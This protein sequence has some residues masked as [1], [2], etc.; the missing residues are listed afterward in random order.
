M[1]PIER[2]ASQIYLV[3]EQNV[4]LDADLA[5]LYGVETRALVQAVKRNA[6]RFP[7]DFMFQLSKDELESWRSQIVMSNP[8]AKMGLRRQPYAFTEHGVA[9]LSSVLR[10][11][12]AVEIN[13][14]IVRTFVKLRRLLA[15]NAELAL[16]VAQHDQEIGI[17]F[18]H[19]QALLEPPAPKKS[20][21]IGFIH[22]PKEE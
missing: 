17:L 12:R 13:I 4:M 9:M 16:K 3:R 14:I 10:S 5:G 6:D 7:E 21:P 2:I 15:T 20:H 19:V 11:K 18:E 8:G 1:I 22:S